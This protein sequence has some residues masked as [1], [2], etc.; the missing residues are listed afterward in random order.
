MYR[1][2]G[3]ADDVGGKRHV[4]IA[5]TSMPVTDFWME[6]AP[7][8]ACFSHEL[9]EFDVVVLVATHETS[10]GDLARAY[11]LARVAL[12]V[13]GATVPSLRESFEVV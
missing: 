8:D 5:Q 1:C 9:I 7:F 10:P 13:I 12:V 2:D 11:D 4:Q 3:A 6:Y